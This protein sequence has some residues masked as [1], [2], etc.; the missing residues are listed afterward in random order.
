MIGGGG[1]GKFFNLVRGALSRCGPG[2]R[3]SRSVNKTRLVYL[4][5]ASVDRTASLARATPHFETSHAA[6]LS[7]LIGD[8]ETLIA[9]RTPRP[10]RLAAAILSR[11]LAKLRNARRRQ[12]QQQQQRNRRRRRTGRGVPLLCGL[13]RI[14]S[15]FGRSRQQQHGAAPKGNKDRRIVFDQSLGNGGARLTDTLAKSAIK[16]DDETKVQP[17][18]TDGSRLSS[19]RGS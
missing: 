17:V 16:A 9:P 5:A 10:N 19:V 7:R 14:T 13:N 1:G 3:Q 4:A 15:C 6:A 11:L 18:K 12:Q 2:G 8:N